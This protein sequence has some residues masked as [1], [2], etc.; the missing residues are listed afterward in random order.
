MERVKDQFYGRE[1]LLREVVTGVL[2]APQPASFS[3]VG[4]KLAGKSRLLAHLAAAHG[5]LR[6]EA[7]AGWRPLPLRDAGRVLVLLIDCDWPE[8]R[9]DLLGHIADR[10]THHLTQVEPVDLNWA[11]VEAQIGADRRVWQMSRQLNQVG[12]RL[13]LLLDAFDILF[14]QELLT[15]EIAQGLRRLTREAGLVVATEQPLH[16]LDRDPAA[17]PLFNDMTQLFIGLL[18]PEAARQWL[19]AYRA[20]VPAVAELEDAL[21]LWTGNHPYLLYR[22]DDILAEVE[23]MLGPDGRICPDELPLV[24]LRLAEHGRLLFVTFWRTLHHPP[25]RIDQGRLM[26]VVERLVVGKL[27]A[28][29][30]ERNQISILNWLINQGM[31]VYSQQSYRLFSPLFSEFLANRQARAATL[32]ARPAPAAP[33]PTDEALYTRLTKTET[34]LLRYFQT[35]SHAVISPEQ[36]LA[37]VWRRPDASPR[38]VQEAIRRLR[39]E[40]AQISPP[41]GAIENERGQ[42]YRFIPATT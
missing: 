29:Q 4:S 11:Q 7:H 39:L 28:D 5:P 3:L 20:H 9:S 42:G 15:P 10:L 26:G 34:A 31:V 25:R 38:R 33:P 8:A 21:L 13:V 16:D 37:D 17:P 23:W 27:R 6:S 18:E 22:I 2:A 32:A 12:Y 36:L 19:A 40:L 24:R 41:I 35:H 14:E 30:V 1:R